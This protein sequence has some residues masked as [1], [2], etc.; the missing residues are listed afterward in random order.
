MRWWD[1]PAALE[2][3]RTLFPDP[4]SEETF[5]AELAGVPDGRYY[6]VATAENA[7]AG[8][9]GLFITRDQADVQTL[10]VAAEHQGKGLG[11]LLLKD[12]LGEADRR[13]CR[14]VLLEVRSDNDAAKHLYAQHGF[15]QISL[16][17]GYY[18]PGS[19][20]GLVFRRRRGT[21]P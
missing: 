11:S 12:L 4:W 21:A 19:V 3:E 20:D 13:G 17:R 2:I 14:D 1:I 6:V 8:Y 9:A 15:E 7:I 16:R 10:A 5:W 18:Q